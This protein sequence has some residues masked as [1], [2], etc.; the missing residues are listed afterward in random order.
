VGETGTTITKLDGNE[1]RDLAVVVCAL[2]EAV[3]R[4]PPF[5]GDEHEFT[6]QRDY[7]PQITGRPGFKLTTAS[8]AHGQYVGFGYGYLLPADTTWWQRLDEPVSDELARETG[9]RTFAIIDYGVLP[10]HRGHGVGRAIHDELLRA[11]G[12]ERATLSVQP[13]AVAT[14]E[15]YASWGWRRVA[16]RTMEPTSPFP[17]FNILLLDHIP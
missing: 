12:A 7:Y 8:T 10:G 6:N 11:S 3:F 2:Y 17:E 15:I 16:H 5:N 13:K 1:A 4:E 14:Q 9:Q